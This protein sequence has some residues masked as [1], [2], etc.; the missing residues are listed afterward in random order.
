MD[1]N[2]KEISFLSKTEL[3]W[4]LENKQLLKLFQYKVKSTKKKEN[5]VIH[6][7]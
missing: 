7:K 3:E 4:L 1:S 5:G 2:P 6:K